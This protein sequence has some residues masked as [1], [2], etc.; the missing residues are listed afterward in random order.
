M[1]TMTI[2]DDVA[3]VVLDAPGKLNSLDESALAELDDAY[4]RAEAAGC[5][6]CFCAARAARSAPAGTSPRSRR[7]PTTLWVTSATV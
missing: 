1:I 5:G 7:R 2:D 6:P 4:V 3:E